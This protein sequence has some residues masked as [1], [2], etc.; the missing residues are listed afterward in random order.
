M[1]PLF[2]PFGVQAPEVAD[3]AEIA[4]EFQEAA[5]VGGRSTQYQWLRDGFSDINVMKRGGPVCFEECGVLAV[6]GTLPG[7][8][9]ILPDDPGADPNLWKIPYNR[10]YSVIDS[11][12]ENN[13][14]MRIQWSTSL[15]ELL[16]CVYSLQYIRWDTNSGLWPQ[17]FTTGRIPR[18]QVRMQVDGAPLPG[19]GPEAVPIDG[20][21]RGQ[22]LA[23]KGAALAAMSVTFVPP[24]TH[25]FEVAAAQASALNSDDDEAEEETY[26]DDGPT[27]GV[28]IGTRQGFV[29]RFA[30]GGVL[31]A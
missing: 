30:G 1:N 8:D 6:L 14:V 12:D 7:T 24:G 10:G 29:L 31:G 27:N 18:V 3:P 5:K 22:G 25:T 15:P 28:C 20:K 23:V 2:F 13:G 17:F 9:P 11:D 4:R 16:I 26:G 21:Y 19:T